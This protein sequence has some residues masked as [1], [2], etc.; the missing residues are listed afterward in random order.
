VVGSQLLSFWASELRYGIP[1]QSVAWH[2]TGV[3]WA[4][5]EVSFQESNSPVVD[6]LTIVSRSQILLAN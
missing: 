2:W 1:L 6:A 4:V 5:E 3:A